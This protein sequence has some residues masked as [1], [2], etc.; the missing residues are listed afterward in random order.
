MSSN[1][2]QAK[3]EKI[4]NAMFDFQDKHGDAQGVVV[5]DK[6]VPLEEYKQMK[7][8][9]FYKL[10]GWVIAI[11]SLIGIMIACAEAGGS[12][13]CIEYDPFDMN[14]CIRYESQQ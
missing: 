13:V 1:N 2:K 5:G 4:I 3:D 8:Q 12:N 9:E 6:I 14:K 7:E 10:V 11:G